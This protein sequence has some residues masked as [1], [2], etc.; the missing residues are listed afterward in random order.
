MTT[1]P[2][3]MQAVA[4]PLQQ[5]ISKV[6]DNANAFIFSVLVFSYQAL[7]TEFPCSCKPQPGYCCAY[8]ILPCLI[9]TILMLSTD[10]PFQRAWNY[11]SSKGSCHFGC[12]LFRRAVKALCVGLLWVA[13]VLIDGEWFVC[14]YNQN[15]KQVADL[16]CKSK[17]D[18]TP[19]DTPVVTIAEM[20]MNS[21]LIG[22]SVLFGITFI[23]AILLS[24]WPICADSCCLA[25]C[26]RD[27]EVHELILEAGEDIVS[28]TMK[29]EQ[30]SKLSANVKKYINQGKWVNC[31]DVVEEFIDTIG[32]DETKVQHK[33]SVKQ[34][35]DSV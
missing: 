21:R 4:A 2:P 34:S 24:T 28:K 8:M 6:K 30:Q 5:F 26:K 7:E 20:K 23:G 14:C 31:L 10:L 17:T 19:G 33:V 12:V 32:R 22:M 35:E 3:K 25:C 29:E 11:T 15:N 9:I 27:I 16:Q 1:S 18:I 13:S